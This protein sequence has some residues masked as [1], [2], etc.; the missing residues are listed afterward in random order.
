MATPIGCSTFII[1]YNLITGVPMNTPQQHESINA[2][3]LICKHTN[4]Y[5][6]KHVLAAI[7]M[8]SNR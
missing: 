8:T 4:V 5:F 1:T 3:I 2:F 7:E 6:N